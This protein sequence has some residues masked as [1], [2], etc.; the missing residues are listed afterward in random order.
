MNG[1]SILWIK[2]QRLCGLPCFHKQERKKQIA[3]AE[4]YST[5]MCLFTKEDM[6]C[7]GCHSDTLSEKMCGDC[8]IRKCGHEKAFTT[9]AAC[10]VFPCAVLENRFGPES[11][12]MNQLKQLAVKYNRQK[13]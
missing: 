8:E 1:I 12:Q 10:D 11:D 5:D 2:L 4:E 6:F 3:L 9:C 7:L 13:G